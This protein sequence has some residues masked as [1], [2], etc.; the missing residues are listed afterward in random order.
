MGREGAV[1]WGATVFGGELRL[2]V[3]G[4][5]V[6]RQVARSSDECDRASVEWKAAMFGA[7][8]REV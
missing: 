2:D 6:R 7:V 3:N 8:W 1:G 5:L 4:G